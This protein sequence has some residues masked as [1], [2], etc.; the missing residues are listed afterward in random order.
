[1]HEDFNEGTKIALNLDFFD[2]TNLGCFEL[3]NIF[4][5]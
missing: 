2:S 5:G 1:M 4:A 3:E